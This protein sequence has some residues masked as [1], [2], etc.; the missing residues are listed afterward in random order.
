MIR[1][2]GTLIANINRQE[3]SATTQPPMSGPTIA[4]IAPHAVQVPIAALRWCVGN[5]LTMTA[6]ALGARTAPETPC[7]AR[8]AISTPL[9][10]AIAHSSEKPPKETTPSRN[11]RCSP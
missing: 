1:T 8:A 2:S 6:K 5:A 11:A 4:A 7:N 9:S 10:G 3:A